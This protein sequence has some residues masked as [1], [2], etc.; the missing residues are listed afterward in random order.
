MLLLGPFLLAACGDDSSEG[1]GGDGD[2]TLRVTRDGPI[3]PVFHPVRA[4]DNTY[5]LLYLIYSNLVHLESD[6]KTVIPDLAESWEA[7][8]DATTFT[9]T[10]AAGGKWR[11]GEAVTVCSE[12]NNRRSRVRAFA[13]RDHFCV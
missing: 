7:A 9:F 4:T 11:D 13:V 8:A 2:T 6:E 5:P 1:G 3:F 12:T 10:L